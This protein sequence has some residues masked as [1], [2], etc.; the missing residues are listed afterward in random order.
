LDENNHRQCEDNHADLSLPPYFIMSKDFGARG[1]HRY[2]EDDTPYIQNAIDSAAVSGGIV[3]IPPGMYFLSN[4]LSDIDDFGIKMSGS[5]DNQSERPHYNIISNNQVQAIGD[6]GLIL[7]NA[8]DNPIRQNTIQGC[9]ADGILLLRK[10]KK[11]DLTPTA[12][13]W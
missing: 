1:N 10:A 11:L 3:F 6:T 12:I 8:F 7:V 4:I 13:T 9:N 5:A 2:D